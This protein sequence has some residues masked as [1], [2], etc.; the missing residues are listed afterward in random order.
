MSMGFIEWSDEGMEV[1]AEF[2]KD[3]DWTGVDL[4]KV[5]MPSESWFLFTPCGV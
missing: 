2:V 5:I 3:L 1:F 4:C